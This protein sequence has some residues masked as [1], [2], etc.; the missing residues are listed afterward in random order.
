MNRRFLALVI[1]SALLIGAMLPLPTMAKAPDGVFTKGG[2]FVVQMA[3]LPVVAYDGR[4][5]GFKA[6]KAGHGQKI[7]PTSAKV[8]KYA[9][10]LAAKQ[11]AKLNSVGGGKKLYNYVYSFNGF[12]A[13]LSA[14]KARL[15]RKS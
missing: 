7:D 14:K 3:G 15:I 1:G 12:A 8:Q 9:D 10:F 5:A 6:T 2:V 4:V 11:N 13:R